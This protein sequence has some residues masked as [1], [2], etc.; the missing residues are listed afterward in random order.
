MSKK[1]MPNTS[2]RASSHR[3][4]NDEDREQE[5][6]SLSRKA[7]DSLQV[8]LYTEGNE[9]SI[10]NN[11]VSMSPRERL[12]YVE[13]KK[14]WKDNNKF[15]AGNSNL[16]KLTRMLQTEVIRCKPNNILDF[17]NDEFFSLENQT[18]LRNIIRD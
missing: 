15:L 17:I 7:T 13:D 4:N 10:A 2:G 14:Q 5:R 6:A 18:S 11:S 3:S 12:S 1:M 9:E 16:N 8:A